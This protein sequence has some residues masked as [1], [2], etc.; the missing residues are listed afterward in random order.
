[1]KNLIPSYIRVPVVFF[2]ICGLAEFFIDSGDRPAFMKYPSVMLFLGL[3]LLIIIALEVIVAA[4]ENVMFQGLDEEA[5]ERY[6]A[7]KNKKVECI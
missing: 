5:K 1:M 4:L 2:T 3:V 6:L 7:A